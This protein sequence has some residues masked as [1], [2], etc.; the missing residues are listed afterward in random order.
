MGKKKPFID[1]KNASVYHLVRRSNRDVGGQYDEETGEPLDVPREFVLMP[2]AETQR[3]ID[4]RK[5]T[6]AEMQSQAT[7]QE[8]GTGSADDALALAKAQLKAANLIDDYD[9]DKHMMPIT[10]SGVFYGKEGKQH[11]PSNDYRSQNIPIPMEPVIKEM[12]RQLDAIAI[13]ADCMDDDVAQALFDYEDGEFE[14]ILDDFCLTAAEEPENAGDEP[15]VF[16]FDAHVER[17][18]EKARME[19]NG[20]LRVAPE[21]HE[22]WKRSAM[23]FQG[24]KPFKKD[25]N[26]V[27]D[28]IDYDNDNVR[29]DVDEFDLESEIDMNPGVMAKLNPEEEKALCQKFEQTLLEYDSDEIGD[30]DEVFSETHGDKPLEGDV[31]IEAALDQFIQEKKDDILLKG[32]RHMEKR[33]GGGSKVFVN[34]ALVP[35]NAIDVHDFEEDE[36]EAKQRVEEVLAEAD[37]FLANPEVDLPPEEVFIDG[38][39]YYTMKEHNP[40]DCESILSTYSN[41]DNNP[42]V[43]KRNSSRRRRKKKNKTDANGIDVY[44]DETIPEDQP[45]QI[46]LS[47]KTGLPLGVLPERGT[48]DDEYFGEETFVSVNKGEA[49]KK[50]ESKEEK[51]TRKK[52]LKEERQISRIQKKMMRE[53]FE[54]EFSKRAGAIGND[55]AGKSVFKYS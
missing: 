3:K 9:Y 31:Q 29:G 42:A 48:K 50:N 16:D 1:K 14:E 24:F 32:S 37:E 51:K 43:I 41:V 13:T 33:Y 54:D 20:G 18:I 15:D 44:D 38:K 55:V 23:E 4:H 10:G 19:E 6:Q 30:L 22:A 39:S 34:H 17:L 26:D 2:T 5:Q 45:V 35:F 40:W 49:R 21:D 7:L 36:E 46:L 47:D 52:A 11:D 25:E 53:A 12:D 28:G 27:E 8:S